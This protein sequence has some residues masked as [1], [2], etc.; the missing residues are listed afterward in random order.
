[1]AQLARPGGHYLAYC[2]SQQSTTSAQPGVVF[3]GGF[4]SAMNGTTALFLEHWC[5]AQRV[6]FI[7]FDYFGHG[8]SSGEFSDGTVSGWTDDAVAVIDQLTQGPQIL[9]G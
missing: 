4:K 1:M 3:L 9:V 2:Q 8:Q 7:R 6:N 5:H